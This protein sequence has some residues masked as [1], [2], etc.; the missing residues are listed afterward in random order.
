MSNFRTA[1]PE[2][3]GDPAVHPHTPPPTRKG[4][5]DKKFRHLYRPR[6]RLHDLEA[7]LLPRSIGGK[8]G[9]EKHLGE[10]HHGIL[11]THLWGRIGGQ[12]LAVH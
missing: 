8:R 4:Q 6:Q 3:A 7:R 11:P 9:R 1:S 2:I 10:V 12:A 5:Q